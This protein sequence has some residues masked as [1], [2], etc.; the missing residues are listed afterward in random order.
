MLREVATHRPG[1]AF[2]LGQVLSIALLAVIVVAPLALM[3]PHLDRPLDGD[4]GVY[5]T[6]ARSMLHGGIPYQDLFDNKPPLLYGWY[7][8]GFALFGETAAAMRLIAAIVMSATALLVYLQGR[9]LFSARAGLVA[10]AAFALSQALV[11]TLSNGSPET[12]MPLPL[13]GA[14]VA[15]TKG[16]QTGN[17]RWFLLAGVLSGAAV[18]TKPVAIWSVLALGAF[19]LVWSWRRQAALPQRLQPS[20]LFVAGGFTVLG[21]TLAPLA[22][23]GALGDFFDANVAFNLEMG[24]QQS[25]EDWW[26]RLLLALDWLALKA[27]S[28]VIAASMGLGALIVI[29]RRDRRPEYALLALFAVG[30][31]VGVSSPGLFFHHHFVPLFPVMALLVGA[32]AHAVAT[33]RRHHSLVAAGVAAWITASVFGMAIIFASSHSAV[34]D[35]PQTTLTRVPE[36]RRYDVPTEQLVS[37]WNSANAALGAYL[38]QR[39]TTVDSIFVNGGD[40]ARSPIYLYADRAPAV[41]HFYSTPFA[42]RPSALANTVSELERTRPGYII[43]TFRWDFWYASFATWA[44]WDARSPDFLQLLADDYEYVETV[45]FA[46][47]YRRIDDGTKAPGQG[48]PP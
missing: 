43:D 30:V 9:L 21:A 32:L 10:A 33:K 28:L 40:T 5:G 25:P 47:I 22:A 3:L 12:F 2:P 17:G 14:L 38:Q 44:I 16:V 48:D 35:E 39:T 6:I 45:Y 31:A 18:M 37:A 4:E 36:D 46:D 23:T 15:F 26:P 7:A 8:T 27:G 29:A 13:M 11:P 41:R 34:A 20:L 19:A 42:I 1:L 24:A